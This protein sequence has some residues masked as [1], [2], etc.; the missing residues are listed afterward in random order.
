MNATSKCGVQLL[1]DLTHVVQKAW[2]P[3]THASNFF[4]LRKKLIYANTKVSLTPHNI[5]KK[6][7]IKKPKKTLNLSYKLFD[8]DD[9]LVT[10]LCQ[11][12]KKNEYAPIFIVKEIQ[13][14][15]VF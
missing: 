7:M 13:L 9:T 1:G 2:T 11:E 6:N 15:W 10:T 4:L 14:L 8:S 5:N 12:E 3:F